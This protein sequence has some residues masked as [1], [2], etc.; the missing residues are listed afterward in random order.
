MEVLHDGTRASAVG[1]AASVVAL[2]GEL[3]RR[4]LAPEDFTV[5]R[6]RLEYVFTTLTARHAAGGAA[7]A[8]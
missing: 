4:G 8:S 6:R 2:A 3:S 5:S 7:V 1:D